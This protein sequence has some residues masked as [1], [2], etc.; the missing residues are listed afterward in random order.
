MAGS[1][2]KSRR[3][4]RKGSDLQNLLIEFN[5][6]VQYG[7]PLTYRVE[8]L[9]ANGDI[10]AR[11]VWILPVA[12]AVVSAKVVWEA[13]SVG[14]DGSN[15]AVVTLR[16]ITE[17]VDIATVT[18]TANVTANAATTLTITAANADTAAN[19][20]L[21]IVVTTGTTADLG[22]FTFNVFWTPSDRIANTSGTVISA[23]AG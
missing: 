3:M 20:V 2:L 19:D 5:K 12:G 4:T 9:A 21:G 16:N 13:A 23:T 17:G 6:L 15:T 11:G 10:T 14:V 18:L 8:D 1:T 7:V 22:R